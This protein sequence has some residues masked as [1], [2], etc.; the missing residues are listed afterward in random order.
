MVPNMPR[1]SKM[2]DFSRAAFA[3]IL[4]FAG[5]ASS[6]AADKTETPHLAFVTE[7]IRQLAATENLRASAEQELK[8][9]KERERLTAVIYSSTAT[10]LELRTQINV[11]N[12][13]RLNPPF[14]TL[15]PNITAFYGQKID[16]YQ[17][18]IDIASV[19]VAGPKANVDYGK[20]SAEMPKIRASLEYVDHSLFSAT[21]LVFA[22]L[23]D[24]KPDSKNHLSHLIITK[25]ERAALIRTLDRRF[26]SKLDQK[27]ST[28]TVGAASLMK[29]FLRKDYL[30]ADEPWE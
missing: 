14:E 11:L 30:C 13:M 23:I 5:I 22:T 27:N 17:S 12:D 15:I 9:S 18:M 28:Y 2:S 26:G 8:Q 29:E 25:A 10:Q 3:L 6:F 4:A 7:Y 21:P 20:L 1:V 24:Q 16:L 19:F